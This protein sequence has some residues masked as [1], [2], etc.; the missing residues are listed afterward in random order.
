MLFLFI[1]NV[2]IFNPINT[3]VFMLNSPCSV[4][5][6]EKNL[7]LFEQEVRSIKE[8]RKDILPSSSKQVPIGLDLPEGFTIG[9]AIGEGDC[10]FD[11]VVQGLN[12]VKPEM[13]RTAKS[14]RNICRLFAEKQRN[15]GS[16]WFTE[17]LKNEGKSVSYYIS[18]IGF[19]ADDIK[20]ESKA[21]DKLKLNMP[22]RGLPKIEGRIICLTY[23]VRLHFI[24]A[25][26]N[27]DKENVI[28][29]YIIDEKGC[30]SNILD[31]EISNK[32]VYCR[33]NT[34]HIIN[35]DFHFKPILRE[36]V[37]QMLPHC[38]DT[39]ADEGLQYKQSCELNALTDCRSTVGTANDTDLTDYEMVKRATLFVRIF[40]EEFE[41]KLSEFFKEAKPG[42][43]TRKSGKIVDQ[44]ASIVN[45]F[46]PPGQERLIVS[47]LCESMVFFS[48]K[49]HRK[50]AKKVSATVTPFKNEIREILVKASLEIF[51]SFESQFTKIKDT[52]QLSW[53]RGIEKLAIDAVSRV[54]NYISVHSQEEGFSVGLITKGVV[55]GKSKRN[56]IYVGYRV[57]D[58]QGGKILMTSELYRG[59]GIVKI[60]SGITE[61]YRLREYD[62]AE[63]YG[64]R[65]PFAWELE[66][67]WEVNKSICSLTHLKKKSMCV[68]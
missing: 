67:W 64:Y 5:R 51:H 21:V 37:Q 16:S 61:Y 66:K 62:C 28:K 44:S 58:K 15:L 48:A 65:L 26:I 32:E 7:G 17:A 47:K 25:T 60:D 12:Q 6:A 55:L 52:D 18:C 30:E 8:Q 57:K 68:F 27:C 3:G 10:F 13:V 36:T 14:L 63:K 50:G 56:L 39:M 31:S 53:E 29:H 43:K 35:T 54:I 45:N 38:Y 40:F 2:A 24:E 9:K 1:H 4:N 42:S 11:A 59:V 33:E 41:K 46:I 49:K 22:M 19:T 34:I 23:G 20:K